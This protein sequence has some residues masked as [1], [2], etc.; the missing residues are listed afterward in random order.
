[1]PRTYIL[2]K[3]TDVDTLFSDIEKELIELFTQKEFRKFLGEK[4]VEKLREISEEELSNIDEGDIA[5]SEISKYK[6]LHQIEV[7]DDYVL[8]FNDTMADL[9]HLSEKTL[10]RYPDGLSMA[11]L[12]EYGMGI[13]GINDEDGEWITQ[14]NPNRDYSKPWF[15]ERDKIK[16]SSIGIEGK[17]IYNKIYEQLDG[18]LGKWTKEW[19]DMHEI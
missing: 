3:E 17:M 19:I 8:V 5:Y 15:Y 18:Y 4:I 13:N 16:Y 9:S 10:N 6:T 11:L 7:G 12:I 14:M 1:M 2:R